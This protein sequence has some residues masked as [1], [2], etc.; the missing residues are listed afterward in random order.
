M[1]R[2]QTEVVR[3]L[4]DMMLVAEAERSRAVTTARI[5]NEDLAALTS[6]LTAAERARE[7]ATQSADAA[8]AQLAVH[9]HTARL[10]HE[11]AAQHA[12]ERSAAQASRIETLAEQLSRS[13]AQVCALTAE[14]QLARSTERAAS[15]H[16]AELANALRAAQL[17]VDGLSAQC[18]G[19]QME[20]SGTSEQCGGRREQA[21]E[22]RDASIKDYVASRVLP[23]LQYGDNSE[24][25]MALTREVCAL[26]LVESQLL[27]STS[28]ANNNADAA[29]ARVMHLEVELARSN[30][31]AGEPAAGYGSDRAGA[32]GGREVAELHA[33]AAAKDADL[34]KVRSELVEARQACGMK[35]RHLQ[36]LEEAVESLRQDVAKAKEA[37]GE[38]QSELREQLAADAAQERSSLETDLEQAREKVSEL[39][40]R[41]RE[42][43]RVQVLERV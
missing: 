9:T 2:W 34:F 31:L 1:E 29:H 3:R 42:E 13:S 25:L 28:A 37:A 15:T 26:K 39:V 7:H 12:G 33:A 20:L 6:R 10:A 18:D 41:L 32:D 17:E 14:A 35:A 40:R 23:L 4:Q 38:A 21:V 36:Q 43:V 27:A 22:A 19:L 30:K 8:A 11:Q 24:K 5:S 16:A